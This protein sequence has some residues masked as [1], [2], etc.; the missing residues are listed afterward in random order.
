[1]KLI[2]INQNKVNMLSAL[3]VLLLSTLVNFLLT[4]FFIKHMGLEGLGLIRISLSVPMYIGLITTAFMGSFTRYLSIAITNGNYDE[5]RDVFSTAFFVIVIFFSIVIPSFAL[6][7]ILF[8]NYFSLGMES[9]NFIY[10]VILMLIFAFIS[11]LSVAFILP[12]YVK[13]R[14]ELYNLNK[15]I[16]LFIQTGAIFL[17][18][19]YAVEI[20]YIGYAF[21][22]GAIIALAYSLLVYRCGSAKIE[23]SIKSFHLS[24]AKEIFNL[25]KWTSLDSIG[26]LLLFTVDL[27]LVGY[28][29]GEKE[30]GK[31]SI[32]IQIL[33]AMFAISKTIGGV[34]G[35]RIYSL[36]AKNGFVEMS[37]LSIYSVVVIGG[38]LAFLIAII[39][40]F[41]ESVL[42]VWLGVEYI[43]LS[44]LILY[45]LILFPLIM[46]TSAIPHV[47]TA[48][49]KIKTP[50]TW[51]LGIGFLHTV[52]VVILIMNFDLNIL[53][54]IA[55][56]SVYMFIRNVVL[57]LFY[58]NKLIPVNLVYLIVAILFTVFIFI[59]TYS[60]SRYVIV[61][62]EVNLLV[63]LMMAACGV[64]I[65]SIVFSLYPFVKIKKLLKQ[66]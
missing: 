57:Q 10:Q 24:K 40:G 23:I 66:N 4:P 46:S 64:G 32:V 29:L 2:K 53:G 59:V 37:N 13:N 31:Y 1:M 8:A 45:G 15:F 22:L 56:L 47:F 12:S 35:P 11:T 58:L 5:A 41:R 16:A 55:S 60:L 18:F 28:F 51:T 44:P 48:F 65:I 6:L 20:Y 42:S 62:F 39:T 17:L 34:F 49:L 36:Y 33:L 30:A 19:S 43:E 38:A 63:E 54:F 14:Q 25:S 50:A 3:L 26:M 9:N 61:N 7:C 27:V 52:T 21:V